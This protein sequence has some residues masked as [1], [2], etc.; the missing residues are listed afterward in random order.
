MRGDEGE[1]AAEM[2]PPCP[3]MSFGESDGRNIG[4]ESCDQHADALRRSREYRLPRL[5]DPHPTGGAMVTARE[6]Y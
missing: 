1:A 6:Q 2:S 3:T 4:T 5:K